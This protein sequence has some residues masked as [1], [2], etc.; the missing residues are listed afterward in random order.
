MLFGN[1]VGFINSYSDFGTIK[2]S[3]G[4]PFYNDSIKYFLQ[5][6]KNKNK[7]TEVLS[8]G[9]YE[10]GPIP[11]KVLDECAPFLDRI[12]F[13]IYGNKETHNKICRKNNAWQNL[14][15][16]IKYCEELK[17]PFKFETV[18]MPGVSLDEIFNY[19]GKLKSE[20]LSLK[21]MH[22]I[23]QGKAENIEYFSSKKIYEFKEKAEKLGKEFNIPVKFSCSLE[24][25]CLA[26]SEKKAIVIVD[27][28]PK[29]VNCSALKYSNKKKCKD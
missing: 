6:A 1:F 5:Y 19:I 18:A 23:L 25:K 20:K 4:E 26:D 24:G 7:K 11:K 27:N 12:M 2:I 22:L 13:S 28:R 8:C 16:T 17:I 21:V 9:N 15:R 3:G 10:S 14:E 29:I